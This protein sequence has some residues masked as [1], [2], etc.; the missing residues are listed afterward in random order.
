MPFATSINTY[1][2]NC[3]AKPSISLLVFHSVKRKIKATVRKCF[4]INVS[5]TKNPKQD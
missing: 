5:L 1:C 4:K 3:Q 2:R